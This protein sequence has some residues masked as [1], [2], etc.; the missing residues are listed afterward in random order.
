[1]TKG[2][3]IIIFVKNQ[4]P[5]D[6]HRQYLDVSL[7]DL[8][9]R[10]SRFCCRIFHRFVDFSKIWLYYHWFLSL[11]SYRLMIFV[12]LELFKS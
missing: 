2:G 3:E 11:K 4:P 7:T 6:V 1:M 10:V 12:Q 9:A 5:F 8:Q